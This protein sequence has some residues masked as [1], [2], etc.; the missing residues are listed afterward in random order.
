MREPSE[1]SL[2]KRS[3]Q[4]VDKVADHGDDDGIESSNDSL[5]GE[6]EV[7]INTAG[8]DGPPIAD[9]ATTAQTEL[10]QTLDESSDEGVPSERMDT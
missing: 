6:Q 10:K 4:F 1:K 8:E 9:V 2:S 5:G 3:T 7:V